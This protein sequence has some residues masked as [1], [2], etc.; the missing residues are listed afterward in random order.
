MKKKIFVS[1]DS[2][3]GFRSYLKFLLWAAIGLIV[4]V[5]FIPL[6][7]RQKAGRETLKRP[8]SERGVVVKEIPRA[9]QPIPESGSRGR[10]GPGE[11]PKEADSKSAATSDVKSPVE[12]TATA[13][14]PAIKEKPIEPPAVPQ[15]VEAVPGGTQKSAA[16]RTGAPDIPSAEKVGKEAQTASKPGGAAARET[17]TAAPNK[18][19]PAASSA[20]ETT[21]KAVA[22]IPT[23]IPTAKPPAADIKPAASPSAAASDREKHAPQGGEGKMYAVQLATLKDKKSAKELKKTLQKKGFDVVMKTTGDPKQGQTYSLQLQPVDNMGKA[24]T[25]MEQVKYVPNVK[26]SIVRVNKE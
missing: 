15:E 4:L 22:S 1:K 14:L 13:Q 23:P 25:L 3:S 17:Q 19:E 20:S 6:T 8:A 16:G 18:P 5:L 12:R 24:S 26:A 9:L 10:G 2:Q 7:S 11:E 21:P